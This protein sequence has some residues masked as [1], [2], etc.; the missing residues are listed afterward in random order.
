MTTPCH[1]LP[2]VISKRRK[3]VKDMCEQISLRILHAVKTREVWE[4]LRLGLAP[5]PRK[6]VA[7]WN[8]GTSSGSSSK[9]RAALV[10]KSRTGLGSLQAAA[11]LKER[12]ISV[13]GCTPR[14]GSTPRAVSAGGAGGTPRAGASPSCTSREASCA[15]AGRA[16]AAEAS[17]PELEVLA[18]PPVGGITGVVETFLADKLGSLTS[19]EPEYYNDNGPLGDAIQEAVALASILDGWPKGLMQLATRQGVSCHDDGRSLLR[20]TH[21]SFALVGEQP[22]HLME[23]YGLVA[24]FWSRASLTSLD[25]AKRKLSPDVV[26]ALSRGLPARLSWLSLEACDIAKRGNDL[27]GLVALCHFLSLPHSGM[28][29]LRLASNALL[30]TA[31]ESLAQVR[32]RRTASAGLCW[33]LLAS[34][35]P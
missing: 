35:C 24:V 17:L 22:L 16:A 19:H 29:S 6:G 23:A 33:P 2:Q 10:S 32:L 20:S 14:A 7:R 27:V 3:V 9:P 26:G 11:P 8:A 12:E 25:L 18:R 28:L 1:R 5:P 21:Q 4:E 34:D 15:G 13:S 30:P 31:C